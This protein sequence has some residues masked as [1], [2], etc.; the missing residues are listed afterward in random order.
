MLGGGISTDTG[1]L[2]LINSTVSG[3]VISGQNG[4]G[5]GIDKVGSG[6]LTL[7]SDTIFGNSAPAGGNLY[8][9]SSQLKLAGSIIAGGVQTVTGGAPNGNCHLDS[10]TETDLGHN[11][12]S[13][14]P[15]QCGLATASPHNDLLGT[16]PQLASLAANGGP[17]Q[18]MALGV[19]SPALSAAGA[20]TDISLPGSVALTVDQRGQPRPALCDI[21]AFQHQPVAEVSPPSITGTPTFGSTL[22][23]HPGQWTGDGIAF[24]YLWRL[25]STAI[26]FA[27]Q[28]THVITPSDFGTLPLRCQVTATGTYGTTSLDLATLQLPRTCNC[29][30]KLTKLSESH[31]TWRRGTRLAHLSAAGRRPPLGTTFTLTLDR[32]ATVVLSFTLTSNGRVVRR[33][34]VALTNANQ[35]N[36]A[37]TLTKAAGSMTFK[38]HAGLNKISFQGRLSRKKRLGTGNYLLGVTARLPNGPLSRPSTLRFSVVR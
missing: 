8:V 12:E 37:C 3:N 36:R 28:A 6:T 15:S 35:R 10:V 22:T 21:G 11:L 23:C 5:G 26:P 18:T 9:S 17:T 7:S 31:R 27:Q 20:C 25:Q 34:C 38:A 16:N 30:P 29:T 14:T 13:T 24:T 1:S 33:R 32:A 19:R 2:V 4:Q